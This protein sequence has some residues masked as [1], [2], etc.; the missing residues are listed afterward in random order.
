MN[1]FLQRRHERRSRPA[2]I[3]LHGH[4]DEPDGIV[5]TEED[6]QR[7][8][9]WAGTERVRLS[10]FFATYSAL[11]VGCSLTDEDLKSVLRE[12]RARFRFTGGQHFWLR[13]VVDE[14]EWRDG[15]AR[16]A[17]AAFWQTKFGVDVVDYP[18]P[19]HDH[20]ALATALEAI[21]AR[22]AARGVAAKARSR[23]RDDQHGA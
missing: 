23:V 6:Y 5:L 7:R 22:A 18:A 19:R 3:H 11:L 13:G 21:T 15:P 10:T 1:R 4:L 8:Y 20:A 16:A 12:V 14:A 9:W 2:V 17:H